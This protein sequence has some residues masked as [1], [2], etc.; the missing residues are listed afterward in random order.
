MVG[1]VR[2]RRRLVATLIALVVLSAPG[3]VRAGTDKPAMTADLEGQPIAL[4]DVAQYHC[5]DVDY[6]RIHC[7]R[8]Q[9]ARDASAATLLAAASS[10]YVIVWENA[11]YAGASLIISQDYPVLLTLGWNDR[12]SS[13]KGQNMGSGKFWTDWFYGG[14]AYQFCCNQ[15]I[16]LLGGYNDTFSSVFRL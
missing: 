4:R 15:N 7:F 10:T 2:S 14:S 12:I 9:A 16:P 11:G 13:F 3:T 5:Q 1:R 6:P 8:S